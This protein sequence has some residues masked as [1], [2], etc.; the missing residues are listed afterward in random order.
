MSGNNLSAKYGLRFGFGYGRFAL[1]SGLIYNAFN[2]GLDTIICSSTY[3]YQCPAALEASVKAIEVP[4]ALRID[5]V[6]T[7]RFRFWAEAG[8]GMNVKFRENFAYAFDQNVTTTNV[9]P[10]PPN[11]SFTPGN[12][13]DFQGIP[14]AAETR[15][16]DSPTSLFASGGA[17][18]VYWTGTVGLGLTYYPIPRMGLNMSVRYH[19]STKRL[20]DQPRHLQQVGAWMGINYLFGR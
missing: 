8:V 11:T 18:R 5:M 14:I 15:Y 6:K 2:Y 20:G 16:L 12:Q 17:N 7:D 3:P 9:P 13:N 1:S 19:H 4:I 10:Q